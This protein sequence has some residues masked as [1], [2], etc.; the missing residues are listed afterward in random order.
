MFLSC[1]STD[2]ELDWSDDELSD[3]DVSWVEL[4]RNYNKQLKRRRERRSSGDADE[5]STET[6]TVGGGSEADYD[7]DTETERDLA[8]NG[9]PHCVIMYK[10]FY[11][12]RI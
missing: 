2:D 6:E 12:R 3:P 4:A 9:N 7:T 8:A 11:E 5:S 10:A 1:S